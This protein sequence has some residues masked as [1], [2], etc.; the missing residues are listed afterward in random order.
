MTYEERRMLDKIFSNILIRLLKFY[1]I[2]ISPLFPRVC[3][4]Y[5]TCSEYAILSI[6]KY[7]IYLGIKK[8]YHRLLRCRP[9]N[10]ESC[11]DFP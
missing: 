4:F 8:T 2:C 3:R 6:K 11:I 5:P 1:Q 7:G 10:M 9:D